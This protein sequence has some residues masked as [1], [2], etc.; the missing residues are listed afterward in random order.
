MF[1]NL[2]N[3]LQAPYG[4]NCHLRLA[5]NMTRSLQMLQFCA[6]HTPR[7]TSE[8]LKSY[9]HA[10]HDYA[11]ACH[12]HVTYPPLLPNVRLEFGTRRRTQIDVACRH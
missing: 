10:L 9:N 1:V 4:Q 5:A 7:L 12:L 11:Y 3:Q 2:D 8:S 6:L